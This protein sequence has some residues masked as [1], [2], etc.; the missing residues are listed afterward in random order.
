M[1]ILSR[2]MARTSWRRV[3]AA[4]RAHQDGEGFTG[5]FSHGIE[6]SGEIV[7]RKPEPEEVQPAGW[8]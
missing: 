2:K 1:P 3:G 6:V 8:R 7:F 4:F 5:K